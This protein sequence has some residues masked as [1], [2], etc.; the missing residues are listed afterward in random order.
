MLEKHLLPPMDMD[1][2]QEMYEKLQ[3]ELAQTGKVE[4][5]TL[6]PRLFTKKRARDYDQWVKEIRS[7]KT[8]EGKKRKILKQLTAEKT[9]IVEY[10]NKEFS[11]I[12]IEGKFAILRERKHP[13]KDSILINYVKQRRNLEFFSIKDF[14]DYWMNWKVPVSQPA[15]KQPFK[16]IWSSFGE[17]W[18]RD[19]RRRQYDGMDFRPITKS[20]GKKIFNMW[21]GW[22]V[23]PSDVK[24][25]YRYW[26]HVREI[27]C[28]GNEDLY[29][30]V[31]KWMAHCIQKPEEM[32]R[33]ALV[34][35]GGQGIGKGRFV[36]FF[37]ALFVDGFMSFSSIEQITGQFNGVLKDKLLIYADE[38]FWGGFKK[39][40]GV[41]KALISEGKQLIELKGKEKFQV[42]S[43][44]RLIIASNQAWAVPVEL[45]DRRFLFCN[46]SNARRNDYEYFNR[47]T[48]EMQEGGLQALMADLMVEDLTGWIP[49]D[50]PLAGI[51]AGMDAKEL[52]M[53]IPQRFVLE[54]LEAGISFGQKSS[55][56]LS[57]YEIIATEFYEEFAG[58]CVENNIN[59]IVPQKIF[60][61]EV[62]SKTNNPKLLPVEKYTRVNDSQGSRRA[63]LVPS[64]KECRKFFEDNVLHHSFQ[65]ESDPTSS[66]AI[67]V[68]TCV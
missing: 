30:Y 63:M 26:D 60:S 20:L 19:R 45:G 42:N 15:A 7:R 53:S 33:V 5:P 16:V 27:I 36:D 67:C 41:L 58:W 57:G 43:Y 37:G 46:V 65:W 32:P 6:Q 18:L 34:L 49:A 31:R 28:N 4:P 56:L 21:P 68:A 51:I 35:R 1:L 3:A 59:N 55:Q 17:V 47:L 24:P 64:M 23:E 2:Q 48:A 11:C 29:T 12:S 9:L 25:C 8:A 54:W 44:K 52:G 40:E 50:R 66:S 39:N 10:M 62:W 22:L 14:R 13:V 61:S 38:A